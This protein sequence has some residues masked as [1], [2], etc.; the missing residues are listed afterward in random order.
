MLS[1]GEGFL[2]DNGWVVCPAGLFPIFSIWGLVCFRLMSAGGVSYLGAAQCC[3]FGALS[4]FGIWGLVCV[5][6]VGAVC[7]EQIGDTLG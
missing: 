4:L 3:A 7:V 2:S 1:A 6:H 5:E